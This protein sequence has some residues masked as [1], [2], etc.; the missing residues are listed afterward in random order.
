MTVETYVQNTFALVIVG[1]LLVISFG[2]LLSRSYNRYDF[3]QNGGRFNF[4]IENY[5]LIGGLLM[6]LLLLSMAM[7]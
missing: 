6:G 2:W 1:I 5:E 7:F 4:L 3:N